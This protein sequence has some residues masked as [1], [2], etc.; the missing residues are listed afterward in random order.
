MPQRGDARGNAL[1]L[2]IAAVLGVGGN[3]QV[4]D[5]YVD[6]WASRN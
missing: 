3:V 6:P 2:G 1:R 5:I 4:D